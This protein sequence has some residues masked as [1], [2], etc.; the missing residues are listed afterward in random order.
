MEREYQDGRTICSRERISWG[1]TVQMLEHSNVKTRRRE[2]IC[3]GPRRIW[4]VSQNHRESEEGNLNEEEGGS[5]WHILLETRL[6]AERSSSNLWTHDD[7]W[8]SQR[9]LV[10]RHSSG[11][12][13]GM[14]KT[15]LVGGECREFSPPTGENNWP[16]VILEMGQM[17]WE[18]RTVVGS[19]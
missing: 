10:K 18:L 6:I 7:A 4:N 12:E 16:G 19:I 11:G 2:V 17:R 1:V 5:W 3:L 9:P 8:W 14:W 15:A 13:K